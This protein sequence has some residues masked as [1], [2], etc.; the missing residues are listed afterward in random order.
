MVHALLVASCTFFWY[1]AATSLGTGR[2]C[3]TEPRVV[4]EILNETVEGNSNGVLQFVW[5]TDS[6]RDDYMS[7]VQQPAC[8]RA[9][10]RRFWND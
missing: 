4:K 2:A 10:R 7:S 3:L 8:S 9:F 5:R 6:R 1:F